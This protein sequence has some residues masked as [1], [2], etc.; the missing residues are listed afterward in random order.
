ME[1][2]KKEEE[3]DGGVEDGE[4]GELGNGVKEMDKDKGGEIKKRKKKI[5]TSI[6]AQSCVERRY[7]H[8]IKNNTN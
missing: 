1:K 4:D 5:R 8:S 3:D 7:R 6:E 2:K